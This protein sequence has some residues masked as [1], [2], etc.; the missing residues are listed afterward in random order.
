MPEHHMAEPDSARARA[1]ELIDAIDWD[2]HPEWMQGLVDMLEALARQQA[3]EDA[4]LDA[5]IRAEGR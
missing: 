3:R 1:H 4:E 5:E 2:A